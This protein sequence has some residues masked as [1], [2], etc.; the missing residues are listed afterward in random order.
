MTETPTAPAATAG[1]L[2]HLKVLDLSRV[3]AGP[4][5]GQIF[6]DLGA[7]VIKVE[8]PGAGDD[9]RSWGPPFLKDLDGNET[10][11][12]GYYLAANRG[13]RSVTVNI[14]TPE[15]QEIIRTLAK[16]ADIVLE[17]FKTGTLKRFGLDYESLRAV[18]ERII[19]CSLTGFGQNG[20]RANQVAYDFLIQAMGGLMSI[21][22]EEDGRPGGG[23]QKVG[24]PIVDLTTGLYLVIGALAA[25]ARRE[26]TGRGDYLDL[27]MLDVQVAL[28][29][30]Q[31]MNHLLT[32]NVPR[33]YG[34][35]H[36]NI[37]PQQ[38]FACRDGRIVLA[39][40]NDEQYARLARLLNDPLMLE[41]RFVKNRDRVQYR[42]ELLGRIAE[43]FATF[44]RADLLARLDAAD[45]PAG[46][47]N[48]VAEALQEPQIAERGMV[49][50][51]AH[52]LSGE[53]PQVL[54]PLK[55]REAKGAL[56]K[57]PPLLGADTD[58]ILDGLGLSDEQRAGLRARGII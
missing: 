13:K 55:F 27:A 3:L 8:R 15:G 44:E 6:A 35:G 14:G 9:T 1:P 41:E 2:S 37:M 52:P 18:N 4:W 40:G 33:R 57:A 21:T 17:N 29:A 51:L 19:Y 49:T 23:P 32:G 54:S 26:Q 53:V 25:L 48:T 7:E 22:G 58:D 38:V 36:P 16:E 47:I 56:P 46:P 30:N 34:N 20:P 50:R 5:A 45:I 24:L 12:S 39:V 11:E 31:A 10:R 28:L 42:D 43:V